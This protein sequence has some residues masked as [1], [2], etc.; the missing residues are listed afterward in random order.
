MFCLEYF[1]PK[2]PVHND[3]PAAH[4]LRLG[5]IPLILG[6]AVCG[7]VGLAY[8]S[9]TVLFAQFIYVVMLYSTY[10][11]LHTWLVWLYMIVL[12][13]NLLSGFLNVWIYEGV[14]FYVYMGILLYYVVAICKTYYDSLPFRSLGDNQDN[15][16]FEAGI[17]HMFN[18]AREHYGINGNA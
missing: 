16:Y 13:F 8:V 6:H 3:M 12:G 10:M 5:L 18:N 17:R 7:V 14:R 2:A 11:T 1:F 9:V 4:R 15:F